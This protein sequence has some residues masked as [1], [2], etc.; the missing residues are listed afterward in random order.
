MRLDSK[1]QFIEHRFHILTSI[2]KPNSSFRSRQLYKNWNLHN[3]LT[4]DFRQN[5]KLNL[6]PQ[7]SIRGSDN[8]EFIEF[9]EQNTILKK[10][11][12]D[13]NYKKSKNYRKGSSMLNKQQFY[14]N[15]HF[16]LS[17]NLNFR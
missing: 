9:R 15:G 16:P 11:R 8:Y 13:R 5:G 10:L 7:R 4:I 3:N 2:R 17:Q 6:N 14:S 1:L 12:Y